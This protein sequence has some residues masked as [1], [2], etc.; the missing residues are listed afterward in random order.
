[1]L[2]SNNPSGKVIQTSFSAPWISITFF[3]YTSIHL[4]K[5]TR[6]AALENNGREK[7]SALAS[8]NV[9]EPDRE[10]YIQT[11][12]QRNTANNNSGLKRVKG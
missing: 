10:T 11:D 5:A 1:V 12:R 8:E 9:G 4:Q 2:Y 7:E 6:A 3:I